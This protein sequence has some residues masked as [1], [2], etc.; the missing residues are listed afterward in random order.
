MAKHREMNDGC[1]S[2]VII[3]LGDAK[4]SPLC[5]VKNCTKQE[6]ELK[7]KDYQ[8]MMRDIILNTYGLQGRYEPGYKRPSVLDGRKAA[9]E[10]ARSA[11]KHACLCGGKYNNHNKARHFKSKK[12]LKF[13]NLSI[14]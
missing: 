5:I 1:L 6:I 9:Y 3:Q 4:I 14:L 8:L 13:N 11:I 7:E 12:H 2:K 10:K